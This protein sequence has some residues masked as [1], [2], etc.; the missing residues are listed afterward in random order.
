MIKNLL[1][2]FNNCGQNPVKTKTTDLGLIL[3]FSWSH[4]KRYL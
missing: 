1:F 4:S 2:Y 3:I